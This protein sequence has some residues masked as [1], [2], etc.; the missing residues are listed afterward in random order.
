MPAVIDA[1]APETLVA[2]FRRIFT[3]GG[4]GPVVVARA[5]GRVNLIGEHT[6]YNEGFVMPVAVDREI[7]LVGQRAT[8]QGTGRVV[9]LVS[10]N[11]GRQAIF[12][13]DHRRKESNGPTWI[14]YPEGVADVLERSGYRMPPMNI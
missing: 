2:Q 4:E 6:D 3:S 5:P 11:F 9:R 7:I 12:D 8:P 1:V 10:R 13:L 14:N